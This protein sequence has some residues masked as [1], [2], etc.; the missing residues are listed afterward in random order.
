M[1]MKSYNW[2]KLTLTTL[3][4]ALFMAFSAT[5]SQAAV[6]LVYF[7]G[8]DD[9]GSV[10]LQWE[11][12]TETETAGF[13][14]R[15][16]DNPNNNLTVNWEGE[17][18]DFI[19]S[20]ADDAGF[21]TRYTVYDDSAVAGQTYT[22]TLYEVTNSSQ[23]EQIA[24]S[25][26]ITFTG[27]GGVS[28]LPTNTPASQAPT[29]TN[30]RP[31]TATPTTQPNATA[32]TA[33]SNP[34]PTATPTNTA[35]PASN[36]GAT[37]QTNTAT[38]TA[39]PNTTTALPTNTPAAV[40]QNP[41]P[42]PQSDNNGISEASAQQPEPYPNPEDSQTDTPGEFTTPETGQENIDSYPEPSPNTAETNGEPTPYV[43]PVDNGGTP[44][45]GGSQSIG[46]GSSPNTPTDDSAAEDAEE[47]GSNSLILWIG[48]IGA[49]LIF[50]GG[51][52]GSLIVFAR[53]QNN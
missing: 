25:E 42:T 5:T 9:E 39:T 15:R 6:S 47:S 19:P 38:I 51:V 16:S 46:A 8:E 44:T 43:E 33:S 30:T 31:A 41:S 18:V 49:L 29:P 1:F 20:Q 28:Q 13:R 11:T 3:A 32:T 12:A 23:T 7:L 21:G 2:L 4:L 37:G 45:N 50:G 53:R 34:N 14:I 24:Q 40:A 26:P 10:L 35:T 27:D 17:D 52:A 48:F 22:Y 36:S